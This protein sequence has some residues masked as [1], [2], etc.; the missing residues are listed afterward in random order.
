MTHPSHRFRRY[1]LAALLAA[2]LCGAASPSMADTPDAQACAD[3]Y[4][5]GPSAEPSR[6]FY[7]MAHNP[8]HAKDALAY[9]K[10][11]A[12]ALEP[13]LRF[14]DGEIRV[15]DQFVIAGMRFRFPVHDGRGPTLREY[16]RELREGIGASGRPPALIAWDLKPDFDFKWLR[17]AVETVRE[18]FLTAYPNVS[19]LYTVGSPDGM[20]ALQQLAPLL[21]PGEAVG[22]DD[23]MPHDEA[24]TK[25]N[26]LGAAY[27]FAHRA[28]IAEVQRAVALRDRGNSFRLVYAWTINDRDKLKALVDAGVNGVIV[29]MQS[30]A[31][32]CGLLAGQPAR[33]ARPD[34]QPFAK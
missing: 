29:D 13:D 2:T 30:V 21:R 17:I 14:V 24:H 15:H 26:A 18:E 9:L 3:A 20:A 1:A 7:V 19:M 4:A 27:T 25:F 28:D 22:I 12:N 23:G 11:G 6:L 16:L 10:A 34:D 32:L 5:R 8:N 31:T 33:L